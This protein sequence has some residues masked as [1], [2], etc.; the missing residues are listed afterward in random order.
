M[1]LFKL[2]ISKK[3]Y[4][5][6]MFSIKKYHLA[7]V[8]FMGLIFLF[9]KCSNKKDKAT[10]KP[11]HSTQVA[12]EPNAY[13]NLGPDATMVGMGV[14]ASCH[15]DI[16]DTFVH[17]GMGK[18]FEVASDKKTA[19]HFD[20]HSTIYDKKSNFYY[21]AKLTNK[22]LY[23]TEFRLEGK[24]TIHKRIEKADY[25]IGS[26]QHTNSHLFS[27]NGYLYQMPMT[28]Y[29]QTGKWDLP[30]G[31]ENGNNSR[32]S[33]TIETE[34][35]TCHNAYPQIVEGSTNKYTKIENGIDCER[36]HG[37]GSIHV[38]EKL[39]GI[40]VDTSKYIDYTIVN[41]KKLTIDKQI[42]LCQRCHLQG[43]AVLKEGKTFFDFK[44]S[45]DLSEVVSIFMPRYDGN[46][47][48]FIMASHADRMLQS[49][50]YIKTQKMTCI[51]C[52]NPHKS[53]KITRKD[54]FNNV[55]QTCHTP[56]KEGQTIAQ[57]QTQC[58]LP[59]GKRIK[60]N[61]ND[62]VKCHMPKS[63]TTDIPHVSVTD[64]RIHIP[65][66]KNTQNRLKTF[67]GLASINEKN[68]DNLTKARAYL[69]YYERFENKNSHLDSA[70]FYL[71]KCTNTKATFEAKIHLQFLKASTQNIISLAQTNTAA[72]DDAWT[73]YRIGDAYQT[74]NNNVEAKKYFEKCVKLM[75]YNLEFQNKYGATLMNLEEIEAAKKVF[76]FIVKEN[77][78]SVAALS[79]LGYLY[80][81]YE[82]NDTK[83]NELYNKALA[84][85]PDYEMGLM[86]KAG[87]LLYQNK[88]NE[89]K[90]LLQTILKKYPN[91]PQAK[92][93][94]KEL[95][96]NP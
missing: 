65:I 14:C 32:F 37:A 78:K 34:C 86:N 67:V 58:T 42:S 5:C 17:T 10:Q 87:L 84:L 93:I 75:P 91:N 96:L 16:H 79:N 53:V 11:P 49:N 2:Y 45:M 80:L 43:N 46:K 20:Q 60:Q 59:E 52:H 57:N 24:D 88:T 19:A 38:A 39:K 22:Q 82:N 48:E 77:P 36:C 62:C 15:T 72:T 71:A 56:Q 95:A 47:D 29:T 6:P 8:V 21:N 94:I 27:V 26:G 41:P 90:K 61:Q 83:A 50:C 66:A 25:I 74:N 92:I 18:S 31:F 4:I 64:H 69:Q 3:C 55:C 28:F 81:R 63:G 1:N 12:H 9:Y 68:P 35:M 30:P 40:I 54:H 85:D 33:R 7:T 76:E 51:T 44:P 23:I 70:A 89:A 73:L 13:R